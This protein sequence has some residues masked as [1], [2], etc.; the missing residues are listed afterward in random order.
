MGSSSRF[1]QYLEFS[2]SGL[3]TVE[4]WDWAI[5]GMRAGERSPHFRRLRI[6]LIL[7]P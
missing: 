4:L 6:I 2:D 5:I 7:S 1:Q 3:A